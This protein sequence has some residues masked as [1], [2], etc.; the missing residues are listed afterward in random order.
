MHEVAPMKLV[1]VPAAQGVHA[2]EPEIGE[3]V[4]AGQIEHF[5]DA[6]S[7][8]KPG[9]QTAKSTHDSELAVCMSPTSVVKSRSPLLHSA[10]AGMAAQAD[11]PIRE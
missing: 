2:T 3:N 10:P 5:S 7:L 9:A 8:K 4:P 1:K 11:E 6:P